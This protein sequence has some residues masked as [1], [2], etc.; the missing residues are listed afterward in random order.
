MLRTFYKLYLFLI[1]GLATA[2]VVVVPAMQYVLLI[3]LSPSDAEDL[4]STMYVLRDMLAKQ[5]AARRQQTLDDVQPSLAMI[6]FE[7]SVEF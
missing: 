7:A 2:A 3:R 6:R 5:D 4:R 1:L